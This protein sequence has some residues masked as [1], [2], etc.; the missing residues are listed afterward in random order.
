MQTYA[1]TEKNSAFERKLIY[2]Y[3]IASLHTTK[4][5]CKVHMYASSNYRVHTKSRRLLLAQHVDLLNVTLYH[6]TY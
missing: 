3:K 4:S 5:E 6:H 1:N 2:L